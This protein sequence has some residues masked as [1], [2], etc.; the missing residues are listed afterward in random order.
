MNCVSLD[1]FII[2]ISY[3]RYDQTN[4]TDKKDFKSLCVLIHFSFIILLVIK[5]I[6]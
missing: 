3:I 2:I 1:I 4:Y 5:M 6:M